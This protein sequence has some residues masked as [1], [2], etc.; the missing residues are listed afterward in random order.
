MEQ[1]GLIIIYTVPIQVGYIED[2]P[3]FSWLGLLWN[4]SELTH[5]VDICEDVCTKVTNNSL[6]WQLIVDKLAC[7][8][9][10][11]GNFMLLAALE[12]VALRS[13]PILNPNFIP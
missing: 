6:S 5:N 10:I 3:P 11:V 2:E 7:W 12:V 9:W 8:L 4:Y 13:K 1:S